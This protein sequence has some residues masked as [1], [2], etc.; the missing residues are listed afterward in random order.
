MEV[1]DDEND[2]S[3][4]LIDSSRRMLRRGGAHYSSDISVQEDYDFLQRYVHHWLVVR[5]RSRPPCLG[6][7]KPGTAQRLAARATVV[8]TEE[9][10]LPFG[11]DVSCASSALG[12]YTDG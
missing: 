9:C 8:A 7:G 12:R 4:A 3:E 1:S 10:P 11:I 5:G 6:L 2:G